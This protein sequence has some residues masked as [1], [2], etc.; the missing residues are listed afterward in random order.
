ML[1]GYDVFMLFIP[2]A[3]RSCSIMILTM[4]TD[5]DAALTSIITIVHIYLSN[6]HHIYS[7]L[8]N[9]TKNVSQESQQ[10]A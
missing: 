8:I 3:R 4:M 5:D 9:K 7:M 2:C 10:E 1:N 6:I